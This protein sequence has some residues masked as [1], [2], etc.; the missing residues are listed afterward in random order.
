MGD[1]EG[2]EGKGFVGGLVVEFGG[3]V[4]VEGAD[5]FEK[6]GMEMPPAKVGCRN[7]SFGE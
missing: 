6:E 2:A 7:G 5:K 1:L 4:G 3:K